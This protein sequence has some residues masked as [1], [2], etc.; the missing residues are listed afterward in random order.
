MDSDGLSPELPMRIY[1]SALDYH[2]AAKL[3]AS[4]VGDYGNSGVILAIL[5]FE[6]LL[7]CLFLIERGEFPGRTYGHDYARIW[8]DLGEHT[9]RHL[10]STA[11]ERQSGHADYQDLDAVLSDLSRAFTQGRYDF[12]IGRELSDAE[13]KELGRVWIEAGA[14]DA[15]ADFRFRPWER[16]GLLFALADSIQDALGLPKQ[17]ILAE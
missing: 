4:R 7:K 17:D 1:L 12:E 5:A 14:P 3:I 9:R 16:D 15:D 11:T 13:L 2:E 10:I 8:R 6:L